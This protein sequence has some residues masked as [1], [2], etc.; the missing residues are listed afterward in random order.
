[1]SLSTFKR[2]FKKT[3]GET[4]ARYIKKKRLQRAKYLLISTTDPISEIAY[5]LGFIDPSTFSALFK[6][7]FNISPSRYRLNQTAI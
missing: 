7:Q 5:S 2:E 6:T 4:P 3:F 1:M